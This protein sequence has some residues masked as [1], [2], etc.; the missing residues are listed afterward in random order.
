MNSQTNLSEPIISVIIPTYNREDMLKSAI[1]SVVEAYIGFEFEVLVVPNGKSKAWKKVRE[2]FVNNHRVSWHPIAK[3]HAC[4]ARNHGLQQS[5]GE[6]VR[7]LD[8]DDLLLPNAHSQLDDLIKSGCNISTAPFNIKNTTGV[9]RIQ[10]I[11]KTDDYVSA[12]LLSIG[13]SNMTAGCIFHKSVLRNILW[14]EDLVLHDDYFWIL[15]FARN[16][17]VVWR[18]FET[19]VG[20][21]RQHNGER[22]SSVNITVCN[23]NKLVEDILYVKEIALETG[24]E[25]ELQERQQAVAVALLTHAHSAFLINPI[26]SS[27]IINM[28]CQISKVA[29][30][31]QPLFNRVKFSGKT[32][33]IF[34]WVILPMRIVIR[35]FNK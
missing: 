30:P 16:S 9:L 29:R 26:F 24:T 32:L 18:R 6:F 4:A 11:P 17:D 3:A 5:R 27:R 34:E 15:N 12:F 20:V 19:P 28:A 33:L 10:D 7:F 2:N 1:S 23:S 21:Y 22:L 31:L 8:D 25:K 35:Y 13:I 14:R